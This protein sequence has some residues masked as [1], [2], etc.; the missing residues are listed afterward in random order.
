MNKSSLFADRICA[1]IGLDFFDSNQGWSI[2]QSGDIY[3]EFHLPNNPSDYRYLQIMWCYGDDYFI[4]FLDVGQS[5]DS[6]SFGVRPEN[7]LRKI[8]IINEFLKTL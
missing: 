5:Y 1:Q 4:T 6:A 2:S 7:F 8:H 3:V